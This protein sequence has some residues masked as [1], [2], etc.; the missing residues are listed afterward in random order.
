M[1][2]PFKFS[3]DT[4]S[5]VAPLRVVVPYQAPTSDEQKALEEHVKQPLELVTM[6]KKSQEF[7]LPENL[8]SLSFDT[9]GDRP[10]AVVEWSNEGWDALAYRFLTS[11]AVQ[12]KKD[13]KSVPRSVRMFA[14]LMDKLTEKPVGKAAVDTPRKIVIDRAIEQFGPSVRESIAAR[15]RTWKTA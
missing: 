4:T 6:T 3:S 8:F 10:V 11:M 1:S 13:P 14:G 12:V 15:L 9:S 5:V 2:N 7:A